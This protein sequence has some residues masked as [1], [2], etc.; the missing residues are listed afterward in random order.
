MELAKYDDKLKAE[1][2][3]EGD[4][5][6]FTKGHCKNYFTNWKKR[7]ISDYIFGH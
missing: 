1:N 7:I 5:S 2:K 3:E 4:E 6:K